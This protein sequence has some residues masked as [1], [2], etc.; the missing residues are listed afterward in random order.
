MFR[1]RLP[2]TRALSLGFMFIGNPLIGH[3]ADESTKVLT[4]D[5]YLTPR[6]SAMSSS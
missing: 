4:A 5:E 3:T 1:N 2:C 6:Y